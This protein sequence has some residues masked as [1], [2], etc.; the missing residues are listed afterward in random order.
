MDSVKKREYNLRYQN[1]KK[2]E[3]IDL[4]NANS[5]IK[6]VIETPQEEEEETEVNKLLDELVN[7][8]LGVVRGGRRHG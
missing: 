3:L 1:K 7:K 5:N 8:K 4:K 6:E 2:K